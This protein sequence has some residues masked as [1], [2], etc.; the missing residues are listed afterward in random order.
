MLDPSTEKP[1]LASRIITGPVLVFTGLVIYG[2]LYFLTR[3]SPHDVFHAIGV[4]VAA[5]AYAIVAGLF[6]LT[7][8]QYTLGPNTWITKQI[9]QSL[10]RLLL[11]SGLMGFVAVAAF[12]FALW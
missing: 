9:S 8:L 3:L 7:G 11:V 12:A 5:E 4:L 2:G 1:D 10:G 6:V